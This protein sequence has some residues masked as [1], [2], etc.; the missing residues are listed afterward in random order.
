MKFNV[1]GHASVGTM[2][3]MLC[4]CCQ[5]GAC[6]MLSMGRLCFVTVTLNYNNNKDYHFNKSI[7]KGSCLFLK[8]VWNKWIF[9]W[10]ILQ[11]LSIMN[12]TKGCNKP[13]GKI[14]L[15]CPMLLQPL[16]LWWNS[17]C[18]IYNWVSVSSW[19]KVK[20]HIKF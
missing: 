20:S 12:L 14:P 8:G 13:Q 6:M 16:L 3:Y 11:V 18:K 5:A 19:Y 2:W 7:D 1:L 9:F 17:L 15:W 4:N 10:E